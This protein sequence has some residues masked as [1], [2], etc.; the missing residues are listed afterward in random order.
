VSQLVVT[1]ITAALLG[2][3]EGGLAAPRR[4]V[5]RAVDEEAF[6]R[7]ADIY[8]REEIQMTEQG[9][10]LQRAE[11]KGPKLVKFENLT[12]RIDNIFNSIS[13]RAYELF[14]LNGRTLGHELDDW[15]KAEGEILH[16]VHLNVV[17]TD[18]A[19]EVKAEVPGF[20]AKDLEISVE[21]TRLTISGKRETKKEEKKGKTIY[22]ES[23]ASEIFRSVDLPAEVDADKISATLD[24]GVL[25]LEMPKAA[26][27]KKIE[28]KSAA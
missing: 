25:N 12:D 1:R 14:E 27:T 7:V 4:R 26:G 5:T 28:I 13:K 19:L 8:T 15:F 24:N 10:A 17:E 2:R 18:K 23:C 16:P 11:Q 20:T 22:S 21:P 6:T 3:C 9:T